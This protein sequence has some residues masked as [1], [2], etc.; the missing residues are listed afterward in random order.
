MQ[1]ATQRTSKIYFK[2]DLTGRQSLPCI[3]LSNLVLVCFTTNLLQARIASNTLYQFL[4]VHN[5]WHSH[6]FMEEDACLVQSEDKNFSLNQTQ[7][8]NYLVALIVI[9]DWTRHDALATPFVTLHFHCLYLFKM[10]RC[11]WL[12]LLQV[13][14]LWDNNGRSTQVFFWLWHCM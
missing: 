7:W 5:Q 14:K 10:C 8:F 3:L 12:I 1:Q 9:T 6:N 11:S 4:I 13:S 2:Y